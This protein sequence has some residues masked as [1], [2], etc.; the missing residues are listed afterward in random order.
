[1]QNKVKP[2][3]VSYILLITNQL[4]NIFKDTTIKLAG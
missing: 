3:N 2:K 4:N 1:M